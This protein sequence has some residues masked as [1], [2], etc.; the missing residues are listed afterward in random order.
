[1]KAKGLRSLVYSVIAILLLAGLIYFL[2]TNVDEYLHL[3]DVSAWGV[4]VLFLLSLLSPVI[5]GLINVYLLKSLGADLS[6]KEGYLLAASTTF[7]NQLP[8]P[9]GLFSRGYYLK[10]IHKLPYTLYFSTTLALFFCSI[11]VN[12]IVGLLDLVYI[13]L[14]D[15]IQVTNYLF[16]GFGLMAACVAVFLFPLK[17]LPLPSKF[18]KW[19]E[20]AIE[21]V[22]IFQKHPANLIRILVLQIAFMVI[23]AVRQIVAF[24]ILSQNLSYSQALLLSS[25]AI[26]TQ[27]VS[28]APGGLGVREAIVGGIAALLGFDLSVSVAAVEVDRIISLFPLIVVG[29]VST[30]LLGEKLAVNDLDDL[31]A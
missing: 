2:Y 31:Q 23:F 17:K 1:M 14:I 10:K 20:Q 24:N 5:N 7:A 26:L 6:F 16:L 3:L 13:N 8:L 22:V 27:I 29:W 9:G 30:V 28:F 18:K 21:G 4:I 19:G 15:T 25:G 12:G 11:S